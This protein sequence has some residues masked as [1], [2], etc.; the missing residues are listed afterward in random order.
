M[1]A[2]QRREDIIIRLQKAEKPITAT[3]LAEIYG[4]SRQVI[5]GDI[6]VIR[7]SGIEVTSLVRGYIIEKKE[8][9]TKIFKVIHSDEDVEKE[10][11]LIVDLG[12]TI[13]DV[14]VFHRVYGKLCAPM[15]I[16]TRLQIKQFLDEISSG[17]SSLLKNV[18]AGYHYHTVSAES[19][20]ILGKIEK[21]LSENGFLAP[22][23]SY[24]PIG[25]GESRY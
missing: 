24:E 16:K 4:V 11:G 15:G 1:N 9:H 7:A 14:F 8:V 5:V 3:V 22:L 2:K 10:L 25:I 23:K 12:G 19:D 17:K 6:G 13:V 21:A 20:D 18:T